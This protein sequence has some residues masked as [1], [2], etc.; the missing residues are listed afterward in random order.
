MDWKP[1]FQLLH[2]ILCYSYQTTQKPWIY[3]NMGKKMKEINKKKHKKNGSVL[4]HYLCI[5]FSLV[6][7]QQQKHLLSR[8]MENKSP[9][10]DALP[11]YVGHLLQ[12]PNA[13]HHNSNQ[14]PTTSGC[15]HA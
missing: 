6:I 14:V 13:K 9:N 1:N 2:Q 3:I 8:M 7:Q 5:G 10:L 4:G 15:S 12:R 11:R